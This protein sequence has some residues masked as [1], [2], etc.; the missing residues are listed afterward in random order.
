[1]KRQTMFLIASAVMIILATLV[2]VQGAVVN[3]PPGSNAQSLIDGSKPSDVIQFTPGG[4]YGSLPQ[5]TLRGHRAYYGD[6][7]NPPTFTARSGYYCFGSDPADSNNVTFSGFKTNGSCLRIEGGSG[8]SDSWAISYVNLSGTPTAENNGLCWT[9]PLTNSVLSN[10]TGTFYSANGII[11]GVSWHNVEIKN[12]TFGR[13]RGELSEGI[14]CVGDAGASTGL[15]IH[16]CT[17]L[18]PHRLACEVQGTGVCTPIDR[19]KGIAD[20]V[21]EKNRVLHATLTNQFKDNMDCFGISAPF[22]GGSEIVRWNVVDAP[23]RDDGTGMRIGLELA[24]TLT[25]KSSVLCYENYVNGL[26]NA[27]AIAWSNGASVYNNKLTNNISGVQNEGGPHSGENEVIGK[28][29][30]TVLLP[31]DPSV[32]PI[33][34]SGGGVTPA[35][36]TPSPNGTFGTVV[37]NAS[38]V[39]YSIT[40]GQVYVNGIVDAATKNVANLLYYGGAVDQVTSTGQ[41]WTLPGASAHQ[42]PDPR[43]PVVTPPPSAVTVGSIDL[44][45]HYTDGTNGSM[46][47]HP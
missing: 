10:I 11:H 23:E 29:D 42:I 31:F 9:N 39:T 46:N 27:V 38:G 14:H 45:I 44:N 5:I 13:N 24:G 26:N 37:V 25:L 20:V 19:L 3:I 21:I 2:A 40:S 28:N 7:N 32:W 17:F 35:P 8:Q 36:A 47:A 16:D 18:W 43:S 34:I 12:S 6:V 41:F 15:W 1:M 33:L 22:Q 30:A 4:N